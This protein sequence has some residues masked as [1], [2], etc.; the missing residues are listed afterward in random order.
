MAIFQKDLIPMGERRYIIKDFIDAFKRQIV[1]FEV[2]IRYLER[3]KIKGRNLLVIE[4]LL[5]KSKK[6]KEDAENRL[7]TALD[8][9]EEIKDK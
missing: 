6:L 2:D 7:K 1:S 4:D 3:E 5:V 9:Q 8:I